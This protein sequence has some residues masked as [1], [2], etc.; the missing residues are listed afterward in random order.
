MVYV[1]VVMEGDVGV[2]MEGGVRVV[3]EGGVGVVMEGGVGVVRATSFNVVTFNHDG[4]A[5]NLYKFSDLPACLTYLC[6]SAR[7]GRRAARRQ[8]IGDR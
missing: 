4:S 5:N 7:L 2:V 6:T 1:G 8:P 3:M